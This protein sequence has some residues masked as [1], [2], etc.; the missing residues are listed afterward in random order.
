MS[1]RQRPQVFSDIARDEA[2]IPTAGRR[3]H[4]RCWLAP[5]RGRGLSEAGLHVLCEKPLAVTMRGCNL[6]VEAART[7]GLDRFRS[8]RTSAATRST[9]LVRALIDDGAIGTPRLMIETTI[10]GRDQHHHHALAPHEE[11]RHDHGRRGRPPRRHPTVLPGRVRLGVRRDPPA[12]E[13]TQQHPVGRAGRLLRALV[14]QLCPTTIEPTGEDALYAHIS[15]ENGAIGHWI[16]DHAG[17]GC[18]CHAR[19]STV[20]RARSECP[21]TATA[22]R[23]SC[24]S[25]TAP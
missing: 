18:R 25:T 10:G 12:R 14:G 8:P 21:A 22:A 6:A 20:R 3:C 9:G 4:H 11:H 7:Q 2:R 1:C 17:H 16:N 13:N 5:R 15:F 23:S 24:T 19:W